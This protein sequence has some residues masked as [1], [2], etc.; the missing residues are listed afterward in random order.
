MNEQLLLIRVLYFV[1]YKGDP[2]AVT[3]SEIRIL[4]KERNRYECILHVYTRLVNDFD[5]LFV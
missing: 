3:D 1:L 4:R 2:L 5:E